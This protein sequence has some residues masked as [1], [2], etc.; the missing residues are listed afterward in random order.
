MRK[1]TTVLPGQEYDTRDLES[2]DY[3]TVFSVG[4]HLTRT[5]PPLEDRVGFL[6]G[7]G[8]GV[9]W[10]PG[11]PCTISVRL[12]KDQLTDVEYRTGRWRRAA[13]L[14]QIRGYDHAG[15]WRSEDGALFDYITVGLEDLVPATPRKDVMP[16]PVMVLGNLSFR[17]TLQAMTYGMHTIR[18]D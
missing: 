9:D 12:T 5:A 15:V 2:V 16:S 6:K 17:D 11:E 4:E 7:F 18:P 8:F 14:M 13:E 3:H 10:P 1:Q